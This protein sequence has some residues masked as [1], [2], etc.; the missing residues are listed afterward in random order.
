MSNLSTPGTINSAGIKKL[1]ND[2]RN[3]HLD[4]TGRNRLLN[5][6]HTSK[7]SLRFVDESPNQLWKKLLENGEMRFE[8]VPEPT[9]KDLLNSGYLE[10]EEWSG[11]T[12][13]LKD[14]PDAKEWAAHVGI[15]TSWDVPHNG[16][17]EDPQSKHTDNKIQTI[18]F[19]QDLDSILRSIL[20]KANSSIQ[21]T[22]ANILY[23]ALGFLEWSESADSEKKHLSPLYMLPVTVKRGRLVK[24]EGAFRYSISYSGEDIIPNLS[25]REKL[26]HDFGLALP[27]LDEETEPEDYL[28]KVELLL[29]SHKPSWKVKRFLTLGLF[30]FSKLLMYLDLDPDHWDEFSPIHK[31]PIVKQL[32]GGSTNGEGLG[33]D[34]SEEHNIDNIKHLLRNYPIVFDADSSQHSTIIDALDG[35]NLVVEGP[36]GTGKSQTIANL[37]A[38]FLAKGKKVLFVAEK[39]A[40]LEVVKHRLDKAGLGYFCLDLHSHKTHK[41]KVLKD[42]EERIKKR[43]KFVSPESLRDEYVRHELIQRKLNSYTSTIN[44]VWK[45]TGHSIHEILS[46]ATRYRAEF[47][48]NP[49][50]FKVEGVNGNTFSPT[51]RIEMEDFQDRLI[52]HY[53]EIVNQLESGGKIYTHPW[54]G[55]ESLT[56]QMFDAERV[57]TCIITWNGK[58][59]ALLE[60]RQTLSEILM[61]GLPNTPVSLAEYS[62]LYGNMKKVPALKGDEYL[63]ALPKINRSAIDEIEAYLSHFSVLHEAY[64]RVHGLF[65]E[66]FLLSDNRI[67]ELQALVQIAHKF[68]AK[69]CQISALYDASQIAKDLNIRLSKCDELVDWANKLIGCSN[70]NHISQTLT[71]LKELILLFDKVEQLPPVLWKYRSS[72]FESAELDQYLPEIQTTISI[73]TEQRDLLSEIFN[74]DTTPTSAEIHKYLSSIRNAMYIKWFNK[75]YRHACRELRQFK[76]NPKV[77]INTMIANLDEYVAYVDSLELLNEN[78]EYQNSMG[79]FFN[80]LNTDVGMLISLRSWYREIREEYGSGFGER[81]CF[82]SALLKLDATDAQTILNHRNTSEWEGLT[83]AVVSLIDLNSTLDAYK[84]LQT[85]DIYLIGETGILP[86]ISSSLEGL[87]TT[88]HNIYKNPDIDIFRLLT[89]LDLITEMDISKGEWDQRDISAKYFDNS[90]TLTPDELSDQ[91]YAIDCISH[92]KDYAAILNDEITSDLIVNC[93]Y[94]APN[95]TTISDIR[96]TVNTMGE[97]LSEYDVEVNQFIELASVDMS[98]WL[99]TS[100]VDLELMLERN[101]RALADQDYFANWVDYLRV[102]DQAEK[103]GMGTILDLAEADEIPIDDVRIAYRSGVYNTLAQ[104]V[105]KEHKE[106]PNYFGQSQETLQHQFRISDI[107]IIEKLQRQEIA[108]SID[109]NQVPHGI[110]MGKAGDFTE[111]ALIKR[112]LGKKKRHIPIRQLIRRANNALLS[113]KPCF[114]MGPMSVAQYLKPGLFEFDVVIMDE[115]S[116]IKPEDAIGAVARGK[117]LIVVGDPKQLPPSRYFDR[118]LD[119][120]DDEDEMSAI[121]GTESILDAASNLFESKSLQWH[122]RSRHESL[123]AFSNQS[124]YHG[125]LIIFPS[126]HK[127]DQE[128]GIKYTRLPNGKFINRR[129]RDEAKVIV[130]A[131]VNHLLNSPDESIGIVAMSSEQRNEIELVLEYEMKSNPQFSRAVEKNTEHD[132]PLFVKNL[133][134]VQGDERD[135]IYI[136]M[137]YG[138]REVGQ[139]V[140]QRFGPINAD[141][142]WRRLNVLFTRSRKRMHVFSS[143]SSGDILVNPNSRKGVQALHNFLFYLESGQLPI[144]GEPVN[145]PP[146]SDFEIA[147]MKALADKGFDCD[148]QV[149]VAGYFIDIGVKDPGNPGRYLMGI[150]CDGATYHSAKSAR[151]RDRLRQSVLEGLNWKIRR[152]WSTDWFKNPKAVLVPI[153]RELNKLKT[154]PREQEIVARPDDLVQIFTEPETAKTFIETEGGSDTQLDVIAE[155]ITIDPHKLEEALLHFE[156]DKIRVAHPNTPVDERLLR[157]EML[158]SLLKHRPSSPPEFLQQIPLYLRDGTH[159]EEKGFLSE[160]LDIIDSHT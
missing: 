105:F 11:T 37:I 143:M 33:I 27:S 70:H 148:P 122:Y 114:M 97:L 99:S 154:E 79:E 134:N 50:E 41:V 128:F 145:K 72:I 111:Y 94:S 149:G 106:V 139:R 127:R 101:N 90:V 125:E 15:E 109:Q 78:R 10:I 35:R 107:K 113:L 130:Q 62:T 60:Y 88:I 24:K 49:L 156:S 83:S 147:V 58:V 160:V 93:I 86:E 5:Y 66:S 25:L 98:K 85:H 150:E 31:H 42:L 118:V 153:F 16:S 89:H 157:P 7:S 126:P 67:E 137:T 136:S 57:C 129:N 71:G 135:V 51:F 81:V 76:A 45:N 18:H 155:Q 131:T 144:T 17:V 38:A 123:I 65:E 116:Q 119:E 28:S 108:Y 56:L 100:G 140:M 159:N 59:N 4:L 115:A 75:S 80:G 152:I 19:P 91:D 124:F 53:K 64:E 20:Q 29:L 9:K 77:K 40:A 132:D 26:R 14:D 39:L 158:K 54:F 102:W 133:E 69:K 117:Q 142:G 6:R 8:P 30:N 96:G 3:K 46:S 22:G 112:E 84:D 48:Q 1:L 73:L 44:S 95:K 2:L 151:D 23:L 121:E 21:E 104:E 92:T 138:P 146:D 87:N 12:K 74:F 82:A 141:V 32:L 43:T 36:P 120:A 34:P 63:L 68:T 52:H 61:T 55:V 13:Q 110:A 47:V 103:R